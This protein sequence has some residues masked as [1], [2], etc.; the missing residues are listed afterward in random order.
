MTPRNAVELT[1]T[2]AGPAAGP[3]AQF[4]P[5]Q[6]GCFAWRAPAS[7][8]RNQH[9]SLRMDGP[10]AR[11]LGAPASLGPQ[12][13]CYL[14]VSRSV[15]TCERRWIRRAVSTSS[16]ID[17]CKTAHQPT[18]LRRSSVSSIR[19]QTDRFCLDTPVLASLICRFSTYS[20]LAVRTLTSE[21]WRETSARRGL[22]MEIDR[23]LFRPR[24]RH[25]DGERSLGASRRQ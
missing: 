12:P 20:T 7:S 3:A 2:A 10:A 8:V 9:C 6:R 15:F 18:Q 13:A 19:R 14:T 22:Q 21:R 25:A 1:L 17:R 11:Q 24:R 16:P 4:A 5:P 23:L